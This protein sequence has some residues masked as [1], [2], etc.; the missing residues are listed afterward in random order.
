MNVGVNRPAIRKILSASSHLLFSLA[1]KVLT[2]DWFVNN[3]IKVVYEIF[4]KFSVRIFCA[5]HNEKYFLIDNYYK[6]IYYWSSQKWV[7]FLEDVLGI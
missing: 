1:R 4:L 3:F 2:S 5:K 7:L 6:S